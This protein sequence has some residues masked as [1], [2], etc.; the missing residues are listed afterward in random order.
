[1]PLTLYTHNARN[2]IKVLFNRLSAATFII[3]LKNGSEEAKCTLIYSFLYPQLRKPIFINK[4][5][6]VIV[7]SPRAKDEVKIASV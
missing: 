1:M 4:S 6:H 2:S 7:F 3:Y 5:P